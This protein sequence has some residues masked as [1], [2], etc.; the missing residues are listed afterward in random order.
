MNKKDFAVGIIAN[1]IGTE[2]TLLEFQ[3]GYGQTMAEVPF[4]LTITPPS[5]ITTLGNSEKV[6]VTA[7]VD[8]EKFTIVRAQ[9]D[10]ADTALQPGGVAPVAL[11]GS[12]IGI[13]NNIC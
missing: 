1:N 12:Y 9:G 13:R 4:Y 6:L 3:A 11:S 7:K 10:L 2:G 5:Q 8:D